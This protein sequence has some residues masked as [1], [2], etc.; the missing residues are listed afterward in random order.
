MPE[1]GFHRVLTV[2]E[3][4]LIYILVFNYCKSKSNIYAVINIIV[5]TVFFEG[6][7]VASEIILNKN[8]L[9][10]FIEG[11][12]VSPI[13]KMGIIASRRIEGSMGTPVMFGWIT[14][15]L[16]FILLPFA[17]IDNSKLKFNRKYILYSLFLVFGFGLLTMTRNAL[18]GEILLAPLGIFLLSKYYNPRLKKWI[19][20]LYIALIIVTTLFYLL[21]G[22]SEIISQRSSDSNEIEGSWAIRMNALNVGLRILRAYPIFGMGVGMTS[23]YS[24][25]LKILDP[26]FNNSEEQGDAS[27]AG[28]H[29]GHAM[30]F[31]EMGFV[32]YIIYLSFL[33][34]FLLKSYRLVRYS[35]TTIFVQVGIVGLLTV[36]YVIISDFLGMALSIREGMF[37]FSLCLGMVSSSFKMNM[38]INKNV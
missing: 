19:P 17:F 25:D 33:I 27:Y 1:F 26:Y 20:R 3:M 24:V 10:L 8:L 12:A 31:A 34:S 2:I 28:I 7:L 21:P 23:V 13:G 18:F 5:I 35:Q 6:I 30:M 32:G 9:A 38:E 36:C 37:Y 14:G 11:N 29:N 22:A 16:F 4:Y 15:F